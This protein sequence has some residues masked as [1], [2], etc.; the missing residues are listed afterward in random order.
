[1]V[2]EFLVRPKA[3]THRDKDLHILRRG[4]R[5]SARGWLRG[6]GAGS[7]VLGPP[8]ALVWAEEA[9]MFDEMIE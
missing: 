8:S 3:A 7:E 5:L 6:G 9:Q 4:T 1:M 2:S